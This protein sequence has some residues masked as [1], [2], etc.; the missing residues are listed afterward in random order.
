M[1]RGNR[2]VTDDDGQQQRMPALMRTLS[3]HFVFGCDARVR[4]LAFKLGYYS[5]LLCVCWHAWQCTGGVGTEY[6][7][8]LGGPVTQNVR[9]MMRVECN[10]WETNA[11][12]CR[13]CGV[14]WM[15]IPPGVIHTHIKWHNEWHARGMFLV[16]ALRL[17]RVFFC[18]LVC[19]VV[20]RLAYGEA[21]SR[22]SDVIIM[23]I[24][25]LDRLI[26]WIMLY[27]LGYANIWLYYYMYANL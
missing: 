14:V 23:S 10:V 5:Y 18:W 27:A 8:Q 7:L 20:C 16:V 2:F 25:V 4:A 24:N 22:T 17:E 26:D 6:F 19:M 13:M 9:A 11:C 15:D 21:T 12:W 3:S 1:C